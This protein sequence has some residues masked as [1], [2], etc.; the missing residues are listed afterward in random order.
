[1]KKLLFSLCL[2]GI[3]ILSNA[4]ST[5]N[6]FFWGQNYWV[7]SNV[8][9]NWSTVKG[10]GATIMRYGGIGPNTTT[11]VTKVELVKFVLAARAQNIEP[12][13]Q[14]PFQ[15][16]EVFSSWPNYAN[17][18]YGYARDLVYEIN[19]VQ[20]MNVKYW[21]IA[22]EPDQP[23]NPNQYGYDYNANN[24]GAQAAAQAIADYIKPIAT[25]MKDADPN[26]LIIGPEY[27]SLSSDNAGASNQMFGY[28]L[29]EPSNTYSI[30]GKIN[31]GNGAG[32][33]FIDRISFH[34]YHGAFDT[35]YEEEQIIERPQQSFRDKL[36]DLYGFYPS[37]RNSA[38]L[39]IVITELN[40]QT[41][42]VNDGT[43]GTW[44]SAD[45][46]NGVYAPSGDIIYNNSFINGQY[47]VDMMSQALSFDDGNGNCLVDFMNFWSVQEGDNLGYLRTSNASCK[48]P[49]YI[50]FQEMST[51]FSGEFHMGSVTG[52][53][54]TTQVTNYTDGGVN[55]IKAFCSASDKQITVMIINQDGSDHG[56]DLALGSSVSGSNTVQITFPT[57]STN[58]QYHYST[59]NTNQ[60]N[61]TA[62][63]LEANSTLLLKFTCAG[64]PVAAE[65]YSMA[66]AAGDVGGADAGFVTSPHIG[67]LFRELYP[68][69]SHPSVQQM[70]T[71]VHRSP[72]GLP[73][74]IHQTVQPAF[75]GYLVIKPPPL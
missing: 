21:I 42:D 57:L 16:K 43:L 67:Y 61:Q 1:M 24:I 13:L 39:K 32:K 11:P 50:H 8:N 31:S 10:S 45:E 33:Y 68:L 46:V 20:K 58:T 2:L 71:I 55:K 70:R 64:V 63:Y 59:G 38:N 17:Y 3:F 6:P 25:A 51:N 27:A 14:V 4:Q 19:V 22:N 12:V 29:S 52:S 18:W 28:L 41:G 15:P 5:I 74:S 23:V 36:S 66:A 30:A 34:M 48:K 37:I 62:Y 60:Y 9:A 40:L 65:L 72:M 73:Q 47:W 7:P 75:C 53:P 56:F 69:C 35:G 26:I 49:T 54:Q 44:I